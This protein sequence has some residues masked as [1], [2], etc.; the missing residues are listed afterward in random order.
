MTDTQLIKELDTMERDMETL[1]L[2]N[3]LQRKGEEF[4]RL[5]EEAHDIYREYLIILNQYYAHIGQIVNKGR[6]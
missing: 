5:T 4:E 1:R 3:L 6:L 2:Q